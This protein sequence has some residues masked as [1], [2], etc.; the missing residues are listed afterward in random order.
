MIMKC[1]Q[2]SSSFR[3]VL[4]ACALIACAS[5]GACSTSPWESTYNGVALS[6]GGLAKDRIVIR[7][8]PWAHYETSQAK[9]EAM[10]AESDV[11]KDEWPAEK[12]AEYKALLLKGLQV[13]EDPAS[14]DILGSSV[15]TSTSNIRPDSGELAKFASKVGAT[16]VVWASRGL[17]KHSVIVREPIWTYTTGSDF[18]RDQPDGRRRSS[19]YTEA[20]TTWVPVV[21][22]EE[23]SAWVAY[24]LRV[25]GDV[26]KAAAAGV[27]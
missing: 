21:I 22:E 11:H 19:T 25:S 18:F 10:R 17:G 9:L 7:D 15:F 14:V 1:H 4:T 6:G 2:T 13:S 20:T 26:S 5:F 24:Y 3:S 27:R 12:K 23:Q 8:V 16:R